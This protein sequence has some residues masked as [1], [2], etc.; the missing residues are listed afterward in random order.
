M[1]KSRL[2]GAGLT[3]G[4]LTIFCLP[5]KVVAQVVK[6]VR[7]QG[8]KSLEEK[9]IRSYIDLKPGDE[10]SLE[11]VDD[12]IKRLFASALI[13]DVKVEKEPAPGEPGKVIVTYTISEKWMVRKVGFR[14]NKKISQDDIVKLVNIPEH[15]I[16][17]PA[18][19]SEAVE[20]IRK[21]YEGKG[22]FLTQVEP[23][24][25]EVK[26]GVVDIVFEVE[27]H[28]K[29]P[30]AKVSF[31]GNK[32][33][34][35]SQLK[36]V[37]AT[38]QGMFIGTASQFQQDLLEEDLYRVYGFYMDNGFLEAKLEP[39]QA[40]LDPDQ[41]RVFVSMFLEE[42]DQYKI[43]QVRVTGDLVA[44]EEDMRK[45]LNSREGDIYKES[46]VRMDIMTLTDFYSNLGYHLAQVDRDLKLD[47]ELRM[48]YIIYTIR[49]GP[50][51][52]LERI[53][54]KGNLR[55]IDPVLRRELA[56]K[57]GYLYSDAQVRTSKSRLMRTGFFE[58]VESF[59]RPGSDPERMV[60]EFGVKEQKSGSLMAG[61]G[62][63]SL[64]QFF[65]NVSY[66][67]QNFLGR[68]YNFN[69]TIRV[70][71]YSTDFFL[72]IDDPYFLNSDYHLGI[73]AYSYQ[74]RYYYFDEQRA[75]AAVTTGR[76][77]PHSEYSYMYL[78]YTWDVSN[79]KNYS[80]S[81]ELYQRQPTNAPT[82]SITL[83][84]KRNALNNPMDP[85][86]GSYLTASLQGAG[87]PLGGD[88]NFTK[89]LAEYRYYQPLPG[90]TLGHYVSFK[91]K[92]GYLWYPDTDYLLIANRFFLGGSGSM[93][94]FEAGSLSPIY[95]EADGTQTRIGGNKM[96]MFSFDYII[97]L[98]P[99]GFK[100]S[101]FYDL[102]NVYNDNQDIDF[103]NLARFR[104]DWG[105]GMLWA[106]PMGP[107]RFELGFPINKQQGE[108]SQVFNFGVGTVY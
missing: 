22:M 56:A 99:T 54:F 46:R 8:L 91:A 34:K 74:S 37:M 108:D 45:L 66:Q 24:V 25:D 77:I 95:V 76:K 14:G 106:S 4:L 58:Q 9:T 80:S 101:L 72:T 79:L 93:R 67:Q 102:G 64:E 51:I 60:M 63:S 5:G 104:Q 87:G 49:K 44:S 43:A 15:S 86:R 84:Y 28:P 103:T 41:E 52:Y 42:G 21:E 11:V 62:Y 97:P 18:R 89:L 50:K 16:Y 6:E 26:E 17:N 82:S 57:E 81:S 7:V 32:Q 92:F 10:L 105:V 69:G 12:D 3:I 71:G 88:N 33:L 27:E 73:N 65:F 31:Y 75:G 70:S 1:F 23:R 19:V 107:L 38:K 100:L 48:V 39:P 68:G 36:R 98:G 61:G 29:P 2:I 35:S 78:T 53:D 90:K 94:G 55:T 85:T 20:K 13:E 59:D 40:Y 47:K 30:V 96:L 83:S